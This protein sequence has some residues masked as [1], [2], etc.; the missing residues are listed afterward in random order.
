MRLLKKNKVSS[1]G[2]YEDVLQFS[3]Q[4]G[5][6]SLQCYC[7]ISTLLYISN[8]SGNAAGYNANKG[9]RFK[10]NNYEYLHMKV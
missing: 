1:E 6:F 10:L 7:Y 4:I 5:V 8:S 2:F 9:D 3:A